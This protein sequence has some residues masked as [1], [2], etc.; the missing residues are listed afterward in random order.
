MVRLVQCVARCVPIAMQHATKGLGTQQA[1]QHHTQQPADGPY[2][3]KPLQTQRPAQHLR[4]SDAT[5]G[6]QPELEKLRAEKSEQPKFRWL[7]MTPRGRREVRFWPMATL[8]DV[9]R[10]YPG[11]D[12]DPLPDRA[13]P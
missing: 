2:E 10:F 13:A 12:A 3:V 7:V 6:L 4:N 8:A 5:R 9:Q 11:A 1:M